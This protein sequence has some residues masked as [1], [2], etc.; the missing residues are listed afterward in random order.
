MFKKIILFSTIILVS[1]TIFAQGRVGSPYTRYGIGDIYNCTS[2]RNLALGGLSYTLPYNND[3]NFINPARTGNIDTLTFIFDFGLNGGLRKYSILEPK[4]NHTK[5]D[6]QLTH[7]MFGF[8]VFKWWKSSVGLLPFSNVGYLIRANDTLLNVDKDYLYSGYGGINRVVLNNSFSPLKNLSIGF[9]VSYL[10]GKIYQ[11]NAIDFNDDSGAFLNVVEQNGIKINDLTF[12]GGVNYTINLN[13]KNS[14]VLGFVYG[15]NSNLNSQ[16]NTIVYNTLSTGSSEVVDTIYQSDKEKG[17]IG[18]PRKTGFGV[19]YNYN[20]SFFMGIDYTINN[21][22]DSKFYGI[23]DS[24]S[25]GMDLSFGIEY[26]PNGFNETSYNKFWDGVSYRGGLHY[27]NTYFK[28]ASGETLISDFGISFGL[29]LPMKRSKTSYNFS[30]Q[31]GQRGTLENNL[32][33]ENYIIFGLSFN[34]ADMWFVKS[35]YD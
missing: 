34:V 15:H 17:T 5:S 10:F 3:L 27:N 16:R 31:L 2:V 12:E 19:G 1:A 7:L 14:C 13:S 25:N 9:N 11:S 18:L 28:L 32:I 20:N 26:K 23:S 6:F 4:S 24:L 29:G 22:Q 35:K 8:S 33:K 30:V 21:W